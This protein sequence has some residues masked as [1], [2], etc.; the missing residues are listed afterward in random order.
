VLGDHALL[1]AIPMW[2]VGVVAVLVGH[3]L[4]PGELDLR[5][6]M[7][8][9]VTR[10]LVFGARL[11]A[12]AL[13]AGLFM[14]A[15]HVAIAPLF[16]LTSVGRW[17]EG[18]FLFRAAAFFSASLAG[19]LFVVLAVAAV[20]GAIVI[21]LTGGRLLAA[22]AA[23]RSGMLCGLVL[24]V[25]FL[26]RLSSPTAI[27]GMTADAWW[28]WLAPPAWFLGIE[29][30]LLGDA[31]HGFVVL[32]GTAVAAFLVAGAI[33]AAAYA[34]LYRRF[35]RLLLRP[36]A[37]AG[38]P[39]PI[40]P[41]AWRLVG[42]SRPVARA[43]RT[44]TRITLRRSVL[45]QG[46]VVALAAGG[47]GLVLNNLIEAGLVPWL[48]DGVPS[49]DLRESTI[50]A[51]FVLMFATSLAA[52][53]AISVPIELRA[54]WVFRV[55]EV[56]R[57]RRDQ[58]SAATFAVGLIGVAAPLAAMS[59]LLWALLGTGAIPAA[60][61]TS[62]CGWLFVELLMRGWAR[63]PFTCSYVPGKGFVPQTIL[64]GVFG[65][66]TFTTLGSRLAEASSELHPAA[67]TLDAVLL[68]IVF[69]LRLRRRR[70]WSSTPL[71]F[72]DQPPVDIVPLRLSAD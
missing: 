59:P 29:R 7:P 26:L 28:L 53:L 38:R 17:V 50:W 62:L 10:R 31:R 37:R 32:A 1:I 41:R 43:M 4:F 21:S 18:W 45:H 52:R 46:I 22:S 36:A 42:T 24:A 61:A 15:A 23:A 25:P 8:L 57:A 2:I 48:A 11:L 3:A 72:E 58:L 13:F 65:F 63:V 33:T 67:L 70:R 9:P 5:V 19:S 6:L 27:R 51:A 56:D 40:D 60:L 54:N 44:F 69:A 64:I 71:E 39:E 49:Q 30:W 20:H 47:V 35:D 14:V 12:V 16:V 55:T 34:Q 66:T 68:V